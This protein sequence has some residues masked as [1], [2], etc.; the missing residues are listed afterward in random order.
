[1]SQFITYPQNKTVEYGDIVEFV[2]RVPDCNNSILE[3][4]VNGNIHIE[5]ER[6][7]SLDQKE[8]GSS[9]SCEYTESEEGLHV[10]RFWMFVSNRTLQAVSYVRCKFLGAVQEGLSDKAYINLHP[11]TTRSVNNVN[12]E[13]TRNNISTCTCANSE[14]FNG[15]QTMISNPLLFITLWF[16]FYTYQVFQVL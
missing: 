1:M 15:A 12:N 6:L 4:L 10:A 8:Y 3:L 2:C 13:E 14:T 11:A 7:V 5:N 16:A 9:L